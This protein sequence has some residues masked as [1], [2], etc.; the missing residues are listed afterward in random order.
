MDITTFL[1]IVFFL[2]I[3]LE[4]LGVT[5]QY[6]GFVIGISALLIG[7]VALLSVV[8]SSRE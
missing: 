1:S 2:S 4:Y 6:Q 5:F 7:L 8:R 3:G